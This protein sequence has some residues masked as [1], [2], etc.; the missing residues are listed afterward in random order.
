LAAPERLSVPGKA[1]LG[2]CAA[3]SVR[4]LFEAFVCDRCL[5]MWEI[6]EL[7]DLRPAQRDA[8]FALI[9]SGH[10]AGRDDVML[11]RKRDG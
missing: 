5:R 6:R 2:V 8:H 11:P 3:D 7:S 10:S 4:H 9:H 1:R